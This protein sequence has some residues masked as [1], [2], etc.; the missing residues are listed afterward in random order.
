MGFE[1]VALM[2]MLE[3]EGFVG[4]G[5]GEENLEVSSTPKTVVYRGVQISVSKPPRLIL[6]FTR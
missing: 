6:Y 1:V 2:R 3:G 4:D 5:D